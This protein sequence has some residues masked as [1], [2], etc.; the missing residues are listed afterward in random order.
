V[1]GDG[2]GVRIPLG[3]AR[4]LDGMGTVAGCL[5]A[6]GVNKSPRKN[7]GRRSRAANYTT[8]VVKNYAVELQ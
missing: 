1:G 7:G 2:L 5:M 3:F 8:Y 6:G 4:T